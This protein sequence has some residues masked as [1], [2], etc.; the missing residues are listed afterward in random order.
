MDI[1]R[2]LSRDHEQIR[3]TLDLLEKADFPSKEWHALSMR[4]QREFL[5]HSKAGEAVFYAALEEKDETFIDHIRR[6][7][8]EH[9]HIEH[10]LGQLDTITTKAAWD[11]LLYK[12]KENLE[13][14]INTEEMQVFSVAASNFS[15]EEAK[16]LSHQMK[17]YKKMLN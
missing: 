16:D 9:A 8:G 15:D 1:Y 13:S 6:S 5:Q 12:I 14:H 10:L 17:I 7:K 4:L 3:E 11:N 2:L